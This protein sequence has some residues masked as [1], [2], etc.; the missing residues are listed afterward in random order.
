MQEVLKKYQDRLKDVSRRNLS[1][2]L[3]RIIKKKTFNVGDLKLIDGEL[4]LKIVNS[5]VNNNRSVN[6]ISTNISNSGEEAILN[7]LNYLKR[8]VEFIQKEKGYYECYLGYPFIQGNF[9][10]GTFF[11]CPL[12]LYPV[13][14]ENNRSTQN[15]VLKPLK[16]SAPLINKTFFLAF[17]QYNKGLKNINVSDIEA[18]ATD[19]KEM[20]SKAIELFKKMNV[21]VV[22]DF[23]HGIA[24]DFPQLAS[25]EYPSNMIGKIEIIPHAVIGQ[26]SQL[27]SSLNNDYENMTEESLNDTTKMLMGYGTVVQEL[28]DDVPTPS[29]MENYFITMPDI[30]QE[31][32]L[33]SIRNEK[34]LVVHGPPGT[35]KSQLITNLIA[36]NLVKNKKILVVCEKRAALDVVLNRLS[37]RGLNKYALLIHDSENDRNSIFQRISSILD[38]YEATEDTQ[39]INTGLKMLDLSRTFDEKIRKLER[40]L[41]LIEMKNEFGTTLYQLY[42]ESDKRAKY[43][44]NVS[45]PKF[46][47]IVYEDL[48]EIVEKMKKIGKY[49]YKYDSKDHPLYMRKPFPTNFDAVNFKEKIRE[50]VAIMEKLEAIFNNPDYQNDLQRLEK[51]NL[52]PSQLSELITELKYYAKHK[53]SIMRFFSPHWIVTYFKYSKLFK[54]QNVDAIME[55]WLSIDALLRQLEQYTSFLNAHFKYEFLSNF[56]SNLFAFNENYSIFK[57][58]SEAMKDL[59]DIIILDKAKKDLDE[60]EK[61]LFELCMKTIPLQEGDMGEVWAKII[62]NSFYLKWISILES[63]NIILKDFSWE[64]YE[65]IRNELVHHLNKKLELMPQYLNEIYKEKYHDLKWKNFDFKSGKKSGYNNMKQWIH[66]VNKKSRRISIREMIEKFGSV[67]LFDLFPCWMCSPETVSNIFPLTKDLFDIIIFDEAS[68]CKLEKAI[69]VTIRGKKLIVAGDEK[70]LPPTTFFMTALDLD[71]EEFEEMSE[72]EKQLL[73]DDSLLVRAKTVLPGKRLMYHYR[74]K[75]HE[76]I[77][78]SNYAFYDSLLKVLP[79]NSTE[80]LAPITFIKTNGM[81]EDQC[82]EGE[83]REV[84]KLLKNLLKENKDGKTFGIITFNIKQKDKIEDIIEEEAR[85]DPEFAKMIDKEFNRYNVDE[86][87]GLFVKNIENVQGDER[88]IVIFSVGYGYDKEGKFRYRFGPLNGIYGRNRLNVAISRAKDKI[89]VFSSFDPNEI[90]HEGK[91]DGPRLLAKYLSY[92]EAVSNKNYELAVAILESLKNR[93]L[94]NGE[95]EQ[96]AFEREVAL[97]LEKLGYTVKTHV[98]CQGYKI[99]IGVLHPNKKTYLAGIE[100]DSA[101]Y[102]ASKSAKERDIYKQYVLENNG[103]NIIRVWSR[104]WWKDKNEEIER[105]SKILKKLELN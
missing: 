49:V 25:D 90:K 59:D 75:H 76:L 37:S 46:E 91:Y 87:I 81:W 61:Q 86:Y 31:H 36:D 92:C 20:F 100:C 12:F 97:E 105:I 69:P 85:N 79:R 78:F 82:N 68:Q 88:D 4:P 103:W 27:N 62:K 54:D 40:M 8:E 44:L 3:S 50:I 56:Q 52:S 102:H 99:D 55:R 13:S 11:R 14:I 21:E 28:G 29:E 58:I 104:D 96:D 60:V 23:N 98:G 26:F 93:S 80:E 38:E 51:K 74:S 35:G 16:D 42:R 94:M 72:D 39:T 83:A 64:T 45:N 2:R 17:N 53:K 18:I 89:Y 5:I 48:N 63:K 73:E 43:I 65:S 41:S 33:I 67:G 22:N 24:L 57:K 6:I 9:Y 10:D 101:R 84:V 7:S 66:E 95:E 47:N 1:I 15:M 34:G 19:K 30:S 70:Q 71:E 32:A 77:D